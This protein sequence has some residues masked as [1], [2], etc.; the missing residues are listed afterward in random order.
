MECGIHKTAFC[1]RYGHYEFTMV[2]FGLTNAIAIFMSLMNG[3]FHT[4]MDKFAV[5]SLDNILIYSHDEEEH[6]EHLR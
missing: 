3:I 1:T 4:F 2:P 6:K 5:V